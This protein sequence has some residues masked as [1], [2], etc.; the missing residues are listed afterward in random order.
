[1]DTKLIWFFVLIFVSEIVGTIS[2]FWSSVFFVPLAKLLFSFKLVLGLT[3]IMHVF[4]NLSKLYLF[5][6]GINRRALLWLWIPSVIWVAGW[7]VLSNH[8]PVTVLSI[9]LWA[10]LIFT[11]LYQLLKQ[12]IKIALTKKNTTIWWFFSG[13]VAGLTGTGWAIRWLVLNSFDLQKNVFIATSAAIDLWIELTRMGIYLAQ[14]YVDPRYYR[15]IPFLLIFAFL[16]SFVGKKIVDRIPQ[17]TFEKIILIMILIIGIIT[18]FD[19]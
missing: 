16:G 18:L 3:S 12:K 19:K 11:S 4:S 15:I 14:G 10:F 9:A 13:F 6:W 17:K 1:M 8:L 7:A 2:W 5:K